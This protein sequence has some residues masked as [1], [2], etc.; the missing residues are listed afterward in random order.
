[1]GILRNIFCEID[2]CGT[3][4]KYGLSSSIEMV[5]FFKSECSSCHWGREFEEMRIRDKER[6]LIEDKVRK[7]N[8]KLLD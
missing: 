2:R 3:C 5:G 6:G 1:M 8:E 4:K 7:L